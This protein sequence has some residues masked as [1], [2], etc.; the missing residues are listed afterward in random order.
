MVISDHAFRKLVAEALD[1]IPAEFR[2]YLENV[3]I[4][5]E[6]WPSEELLAALEI[7]EDEGLYGLYSGTPLLDRSFDYAGFPDRITLFRGALLED[8]PEPDD[9]RREVRLT[10]LHEIAHHF[11]IGEDRLEE[12]G[13]G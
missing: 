7:P 12:L 11:G 2:P 4:L 5:V 8:F 3:E 10:V 1:Q 9:L 13:L 6:D